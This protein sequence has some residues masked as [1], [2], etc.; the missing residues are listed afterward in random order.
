MSFILAQDAANSHH[1]HGML[2]RL[3][4]EIVMIPQ[5]DIN[6]MRFAIGQEFPHSVTSDAVVQ[7]PLK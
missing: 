2:R 3:A 7:T 1:V 6:V 5:R 4:P